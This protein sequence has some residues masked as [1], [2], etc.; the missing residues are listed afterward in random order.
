MSTELTT[1]TKENGILVGDAFSNPAMYEH[2]KNLAGAL[3]NG[4]FTPKHLTTGNSARTLATCTRIVLQALRWGFDP[5]AVADETYEVHGRLGYQGKLIIAVVNARGGLQGRLR[6]T[7]TGK[8]PTTEV[9]VH[10]RFIGE[11][12][13]RTVTLSVAQ[14]KTANE[15][16]TKDPEQKL[17]YSGAIKWSRRHCPELVMGVKT[18]EDLE[19]MTVEPADERYVVD[20]L[21]SLTERLMAPTTKPQGD[22]EVVSVVAADA[23]PGALFDTA[24]EPKNGQEL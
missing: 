13:D 14:A 7:Y 18:V 11:D 6:F 22:A 15:M 8:G 16:W 4:A 9:T 1:N 23:P 20:D 12:E 3:A 17:A 5:F 10:G 19:A 2:A 24:P 21:N